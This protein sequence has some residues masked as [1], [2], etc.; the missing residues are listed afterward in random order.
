M[1]DLYLVTGGAGLIGSHIAR[2]LVS[3]GAKVR[4]VDNLWTGLIEHY[5]IAR[6]DRVPRGQI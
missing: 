3:D 2:R 5:K 6:L 1:A 4:V